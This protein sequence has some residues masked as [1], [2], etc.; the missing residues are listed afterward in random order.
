MN[1]FKN[2]LYHLRHENMPTKKNLDEIIRSGI[3]GEKKGKCNSKWAD[4]NFY[5]SGYEKMKAE[6]YLTEKSRLGLNAEEDI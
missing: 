2:L 1:A 5:A 3:Y 6:L 4:I